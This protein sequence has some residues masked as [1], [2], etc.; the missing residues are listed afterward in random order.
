ML[1]RLNVLFG[2]ITLFKVPVTKDDLAG[3]Q[4]N[5][6]TSCFES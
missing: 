3:I 4:T 6:V 5:K 1:C 2:G